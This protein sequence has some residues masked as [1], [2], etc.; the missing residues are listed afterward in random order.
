MA[1]TYNLIIWQGARYVRAF[2][3]FDDDEQAVNVDGWSA[4]GQ[5]RSHAASPTVLHTFDP[6]CAGTTVTIAIPAAASSAWTFRTGVWDLELVPPVG[7]PEHLVTGLV[8]VHPEV[9]R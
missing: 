5:I 9:T 3:V 6:T 8:V 1:L 2:P 7:D 4:R